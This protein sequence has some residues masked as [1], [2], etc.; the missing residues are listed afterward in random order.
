MNGHKNARTT[1][2]GRAVMVRRVLEEGWTVAATA[3]AFEVSARTVGKWLARFRAEGRAGLQDRS[4]APHLVANKLPA[5]WVDMIVRLR[6]DYRMTAE[7]IAGRLQLPRSTVAGH[8]ARRGLGR[9]AR[10]DP[11]EPARR[12]NR[13]RAGELVH[14]DVKKLARFRRVGHRI[15]GDRRH[16][17]DGAGWEFV[18]VAVDDAS[19]LAFVEVLPDEKRQSVTGFLVRALRWFKTLGIRVERVMTDNGAGY[20]SRLFRK[21]CRMLHLRHIRTRP[22]TPKTNGKA[23]RFIQTLLRE[24]AYAL[25]YRSSDT[26][27]ADLPRWLR[28]YNHERPH[29]SLTARSPIVWLQAQT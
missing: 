21:A 18:H 19:R 8:L 22:Y 12:Y 3:A 28:H 17:S 27:A 10:L 7:E 29:A 2:F 9:R 6:R 14:L 11:S 1:P 26:R 23:E 5:P 25:P 20:V 13:T 15:T 24:W 16:G 4:S